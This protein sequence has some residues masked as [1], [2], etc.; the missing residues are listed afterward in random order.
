MLNLSTPLIHEDAVHLL[1]KILQD[2]WVSPVGPV[3]EAFEDGLADFFQAKYALAVNSGTSALHL[4]LKSVGIGKGDVVLVP[5]ITFVATAN[6]VK[7]CGAEPVFLDCQTKDLNISVNSI[8]VFFSKFVEKKRGRPYLKGEGRPIKAIVPVDVLGNPC[9][10]LPILE[11]AKDNKLKVVQDAT[12]AMGSNLRNRPVGSYADVFVVSF[13]GNKMMTTGS[14][15]ALISNNKRIY[16]KA[17]Y[18][19]MQAKDDGLYYVHNEIGFNCRMPALC[20]GFGISQLKHFGAHLQKKREIRTWYRWAL[21]GNKHFKLVRPM[22]DSEPN[23][24]INAVVISVKSDA[25]AK[26]KRDRILENMRSKGIMARPLW[27]PLRLLAPYKDN[28]FVGKGNDVK[29]WN[30]V[31]CLPSDFGM[32]QK[33]VETVSRFLR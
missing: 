1:S 24:W 21:K 7:Y 13:N 25:D 26:R 2:G 19:S 8:K 29:M 11:I 15:G 33:D 9:D 28:V 10:I 3:T 17:V 4:A 27:M 31:L 18:L 23:Y 22:K 16:E 14:G 30:R 12:E 20:A 6:A 5:S 32:S